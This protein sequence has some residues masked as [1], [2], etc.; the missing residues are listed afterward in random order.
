MRVALL[1]KVARRGLRLRIVKTIE[2]SGRSID[3][4]EEGIPHAEL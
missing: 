1:D 4:A 3:G 2:E